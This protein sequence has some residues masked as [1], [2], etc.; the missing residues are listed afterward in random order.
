MENS[1]KNVLNEKYQFSAD[2]PITK[3]G[4]DLLGRTGFAES[5][6]AA[7]KGWQGKDSLVLALYGPWGS[8]KS[9]VKNMTLQTLRL[10]DQNPIRVVE[11]N[12]WQWSGQNQLLD[13]FFREI[14]FAL[15]KTDPKESSKK[16]A[17]KWSEYAAV[18]K[19]GSFAASGFQ[20]LIV[21][22]VLIIAAVGLSSLFEHEWLKVVQPII[23]SLALFLFALELLYG[24]IGKLSE[25]IASVF[26]ARSK[27]Q[28]QSLANQKKELA[29]S[30]KELESPVLVVIDDIDRVSA[31]EIRLIFQL[32]KANADFPNL[33]YLLLFQR[34]IVEDGLTYQPAINGKEFLEK[35]VQVGFDIPRIERTKLEKVLFAGLDELL[36][37]ERVNIR[38]DKKRWQNL[39]VGGL[40]SYFHTLR[41]V[42]RYLATLS[43][44]F[45]LFRGAGS[46][47]V[48][49]VD[50]I[51]LEVLRVFEQGTYQKLASAKLELTNI[52][53]STYESHDQNEQTRK[54]IESFI[55]DASRPDEI[56]EIIKQLFP[57]CEW[58]L[59]GST[60]SHDFTENWFRELR[61][62]HT[63]IFDRYF[64]LTIL[65]Q[66]V[67]QSEIDRILLLTG[68][69]ESL[70]EELRSLNKRD[71]LEVLL[72]R[73][74]SY[75]QTINL[76]K[77]V[78]FITA[79][80][81]IGDELPEERAGF[82]SIAP[83]LHAYRIIFWHLKQ[84]A[85]IK[86]RGQ[87]LKEA[88]EETKG[89]YLPVYTA[90]HESSKED[91]TQTSK[92][93]DFT[94]AD[95][96]E[97]QQICV[98]KIEHAAK[99]GTLANHPKL[100]IILYRWKKWG[101]AENSQ[102]WVET[103]IE[104]NPGLLLFLSACLHRSTSH[105]QGDFVSQEHWR[106]NLETV[107]AFVSATTLEQKLIQVSVENLSVKEKEAVE[108]FKKAIK[109]RQE[110]QPD[111]LWG[112]E[113]E[114]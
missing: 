19:A 109:R 86:K 46:F 71:L 91:E 43:F 29:L 75:K 62:C 34:D 96:H 17:A 95:I 37:N 74:E 11:F 47:E 53:H 1:F 102:Q 65:E 60:Y 55:E 111:T 77:S 69:R 36:A 104:S 54:S 9:S 41:D 100:V 79:L 5:L 70:V 24:F 51:A 2:R 64:H 97:L 110:G 85:D 68:N 18:W 92:V 31:N 76:S 114:I 78:P 48:N 13:G 26:E 3:T 105:M 30:L 23:G 73:L 56:R 20:K 4:E 82:L 10:A 21:V 89:L 108:A 106:I 14:G 98:K 63:D 113:M 39:F 25:K 83:D 16:R 42:Y 35:I 87:I 101:T 32:V 99:A 12:P 27:A 94:N 61:A 66:D 8:G 88:M 80:F 7:I 15:G 59:G 84:E 6:A 81:D 107:E 49:P 67:S 112:S 40:H 22:L 90:S 57:P 50:L 38:F 28:T 103:L 58:V 52:R 72:D 44:H 93:P 33:V 45:S